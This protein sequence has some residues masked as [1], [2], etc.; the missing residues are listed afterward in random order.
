MGLPGYCLTRKN[1]VLDITW[2]SIYRSNK[3]ISDS[4]QHWQQSYPGFD[5]VAV[6]AIITTNK[7]L[8]ERGYIM[9]DIRVQLNDDLHWHIKLQAMQE[10]ITLQ[11]LLQKLVPK[12]LE[13][14]LAQQA[15]TSK[16]AKKVS[17]T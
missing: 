17:K 7:E 9:G 3:R 4:V 11:K 5:K 2:G 15:Q 13:T 16:V 10:H 1:W 8:H 12:A 14:Y 6:N